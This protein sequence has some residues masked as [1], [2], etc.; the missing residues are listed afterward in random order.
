[1]PRKRRQTSADIA[2]QVRAGRQEDPPPQ[3]RVCFPTGS[4]LLNLAVSDDALGGWGAGTVVNLVGD[5]NTGKTLLAL[6]GAME[7]TLDEKFDDHRII[8]DDAENALE[9]PLATMFG[10]Q[11][12]ERIED[13]YGHAY[14]CV[15]WRSSETIEDVRNNVW[16]LLDEGTP[17]L[18]IL[19]SYDAVTSREEIKRQQ[20]EAKGK[21]QNRD[22]PRGP[23]VLTETLRKIKG[24]LKMTDS[25]FMVISQTRDE[26]NPMTFAAQ[27]RR[28][29]GRA[30]KFYAL[31]EVWLAVAMKGQ[32]KQEVS[33]NKYTIGWNIR[34]KSVRSKLTGKAREIPLICF[35]EYGVDDIGANIDWLLNSGVWSGTRTKVNTKGFCNATFSRATLID[36]IEEKGRELALK[37][38]VQ[39]AWDTTEAKLKLDRKKRYE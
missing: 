19:D 28:A 11:L 18:Y 22:F 7:M 14:G 32:I 36:Y 25:V 20:Q 31:H 10:E 1:M 5:S 38:V 6:T 24:R 17:F 16:N 2:E 12:A 21:E 13:P 39:K 3:G 26:M 4:T 33:G 29:G 9:M 35:T 34:A 8:Y 23:G 27:K 37:K 15:D 30:L